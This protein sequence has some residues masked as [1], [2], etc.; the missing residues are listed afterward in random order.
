VVTGDMM[1]KASE[2]TR[3]L[4]EKWITHGY[5]AM[6]VQ[7]KGRGVEWYTGELPAMFE[8]MARK[9]RLVPVTQLGRQG[10]DD[11]GDNFKSMR[12]GDN[13]FYW[14]SG[15]VSPGM[16]NDAAHW[17]VGNLGAHLTAR[18]DPAK[19]TIFTTQGGFQ[20][21]TIWLG[22]DA[23]IDFDKPIDV[24][25]NGIMKAVAARRVQPSLTTLLEDF[26]ARGD[27]QRLFVARIDF[28][29]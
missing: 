3:N 5:P 7:Y 11:F 12:A 24:W 13:R 10:S 15:E 22:R 9:R 28:R 25:V 17:R 19:N 20:R 2:T 21:L 26:A 8:W 6:H 1:G 4:F 18:V 27:R 16:F 29:P 23:K 14:I